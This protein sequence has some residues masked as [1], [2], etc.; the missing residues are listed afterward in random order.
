MCAEPSKTGKVEATNGKSKRRQL[1]ELRD[2][3]RS[4]LANVDGKLGEDEVEVEDPMMEAAR[5]AT[6]ERMKRPPHL[7]GSAVLAETLGPH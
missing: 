3:M 5:T 4:T 1:K 2:K 6:L 7:R